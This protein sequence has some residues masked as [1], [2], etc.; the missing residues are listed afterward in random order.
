MSVHEY[1]II[2]STPCPGV[3]VGE[4]YEVQEEGN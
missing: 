4:V 2:E 3:V 1:E